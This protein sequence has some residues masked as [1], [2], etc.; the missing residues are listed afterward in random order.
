MKDLEGRI[1]LYSVFSFLFSLVVFFSAKMPTEFK[2]IF[3]IGISSA[4]LFLFGI[5]FLISL[6]SIVL[7]NREIDWIN[8]R[9]KIEKVVTRILAGGIFIAIFLAWVPF[10]LAFYPGNISGDSFVSIYQALNHITSTAHPVLFTLLVKVTL[11][12]G[13]QVWMC[14]A[15]HAGMHFP[16]VLNHTGLQ[17]L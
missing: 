9:H 16:G 7:L 2:K 1:I 5:I 8:S 17:V 6:L 15:A 11:K 3:W 10:F 13:L 12:T 4:D 14:I